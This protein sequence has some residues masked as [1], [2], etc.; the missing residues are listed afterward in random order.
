MPPPAPPGSLDMG[1]VHRVRSFRTDYQGTHDTCKSIK[2]RGCA[3]RCRRMEQ[4]DKMTTTILII[5]TIALLV[6]T[7]AAAYQYGKEDGY[8][9]GYFDGYDTGV[10]DVYDVLSGKGL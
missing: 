3:A 6:L 1:P 8:D 4:E 7:F 2:R 5:L 9:E 10:D